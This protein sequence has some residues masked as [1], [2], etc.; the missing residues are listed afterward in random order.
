MV[1]VDAA[2]A[3][4]QIGEP[5]QAEKSL[6][7]AIKIVPDNAAAHFNLGLLR[8]EQKRGKEAEQRAQGSLP[9][10]PQDGAGGL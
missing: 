6:L 2:M 4:A 1:L 5:D 8:A 3:Y 7:K 9:P 10:R